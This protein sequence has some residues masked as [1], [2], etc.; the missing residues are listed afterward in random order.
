MLSGGGT[1]R[2]VRI[3]RIRKLRISESKLM[4]N[5]HGPAN[6]TLKIEACLSHESQIPVCGSAASRPLLS[7]AGSDP[8]PLEQSRRGTEPRSAPSARQGRPGVCLSQPYG[9][10]CSA[11][12]PVMAGTP[13]VR[14]EGEASG[15][16]PWRQKFHPGGARLAYEAIDTCFQFAE[17][18][19]KPKCVYNI[20]I[21]KHS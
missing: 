20:N 3:L 10:S 15:L 6:S 16:P 11:C 13:T 4:D 7:R 17:R 19:R 1:Q 2:S 21:C 9:A 8:P 14:Y 18:H 12:F 5:S